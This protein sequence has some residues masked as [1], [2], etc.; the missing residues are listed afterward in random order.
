METTIV[1]WGYIGVILASCFELP[2]SL[3]QTVA[4][5]IAHKGSSKGKPNVVHS[6]NSLKG[7]I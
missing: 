4:A 5:S 2:Q 7:L 1:F 3:F 6:P